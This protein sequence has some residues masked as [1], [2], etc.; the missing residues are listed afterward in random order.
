MV[1][2]ETIK[3]ALKSLHRPSRAIHDTGGTVGVLVGG[4]RVG[5]MVGGTG[6]AVW[7]AVDGTA[8]AVCVA[9]GG[10]GVTVGAC[11]VSVAAMALASAT[12]VATRSGVGAGCSTPQAGSSKKRVK[13]IVGRENVCRLMR[14]SSL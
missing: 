10:I 8:V 1:H 14:Y 6:V 4:I 9:G 11:A 3:Y 2:L 5:V 13:K 12:P 7:V